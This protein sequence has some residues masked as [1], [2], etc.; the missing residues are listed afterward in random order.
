MIDIATV[1]PDSVPEIRGNHGPATKAAERI[2]GYANRAAA[3]LKAA[4]SVD[5]LG[6]YERAG[7]LREGLGLLRTAVRH[8]Q[9]AERDLNIAYGPREDA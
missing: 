6:A 7:L 3:L 9:C 2:A 1:I 5:D 8:A 4:E